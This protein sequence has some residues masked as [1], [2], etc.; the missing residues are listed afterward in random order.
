MYE[1]DLIKEKPKIAS[2]QAEGANPFY[3]TWEGGQDT[4]ET[5]K[6]PDTIAT[7]I[8]IGNPVSWKKALRAIKLTNGVVEQVTDEQIMDAKAIIDASGIGCEPASAAS[9]AGVKKLLQEGV[10]DKKEKVCAIITGNILKDPDA[11]VNYHLGK[12]DIKG[13]YSNK[14]EL[15]EANID[16][17]KQLLI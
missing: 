9:V 8:K 1:L 2:I 7:A 12:L 5:V 14:P 6:D 11:T 3:K 17:V 4:L 10:I 15:I 13:K 16:S